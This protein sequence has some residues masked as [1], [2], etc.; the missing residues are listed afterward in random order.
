MTEPVILAGGIQ[1]DSGTFYLL[2]ERDDAEDDE[3]VV[4]AGRREGTAIPLRELTDLEEI[5]SMVALSAP[6]TD[7]AEAAALTAEGEVVFLNPAEAQTEII[8]GAGY[9]NEGA[10]SV[11]RMTGFAQ[12]GDRLVA[13]GYGGQVYIRRQGGGWTD[14]SVPPGGGPSGPKPAFYDVVA[15]PG[16]RTLVFGG[17]DLSNLEKTG[18]IAAANAAGD[19]MRLA[20]LILAGTRPDLMSVRL[21]DGTW[22]AADLGGEEGAVAAILPESAGS[23]LIFAG[24]GTVFRTSDFAAIEEVFRPDNPNGFDDIKLWQGAPLLL[25]GNTLAIYRNDALEPFAPPLPA[26]EDFCLSVWP[27]GERIAAV[28]PDHVQLFEDGAWTRLDPVM[29]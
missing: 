23:Y 1:T 13:M 14:A 15:G 2:V 19:A 3:A 7:R 27:A 16:G 26:G 17:S 11:G 12:V 28:F 24:T 18:D 20:D 29:A 8:P 10:R 22:T 6:W 21:Y 9:R 25:S 5:Q 4:C